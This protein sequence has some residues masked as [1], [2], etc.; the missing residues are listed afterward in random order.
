MD[1]RGPG[2]AR[3]P[4]CC[5]PTRAAADLVLVRA[6][7]PPV[8]RAARRGR[9]RHH[10]PVRAMLMRIWRRLRIVF[11]AFVAVLTVGAVALDHARPELGWWKTAYSCLLIAF[12]GIDS[13]LQGSTLTQVTE[14]VLA[15]VAWPWCR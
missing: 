12:G 8:T 1:S 3:S 10:Y 13:D 4:S 14:T 7:R 2:R 9:L 5:R 15:G 11:G 6:R